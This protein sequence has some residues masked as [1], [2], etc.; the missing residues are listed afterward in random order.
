MNS[1]NV[2]VIKDETMGGVEREYREVKRKAKVGERVKVVKVVI[3]TYKK[4][5][6]GIVRSIADDGS[7]VRAYYLDKGDYMPLFHE[8]YV[9]LEPTDIVRIDGSRFRMVD[10]K[11]AKGDRII[12][13]AD[14]YTAGKKRIT[15][16]KPY[17]IT[18]LDYEGE[19]GFNDDCDALRLQFF[20]DKPKSFVIEAESDCPAASDA[21]LLV[22][23]RQID[24]LSD[25]VTKLET[26]VR[27]NAENIVLIEEGVTADI[28]RLERAVGVGRY[29]SKPAKSE[30]CRIDIRNA[31]VERAKA[32]VTELLSARDGK[33]TYMDGVGFVTVDFVIN[34]E[35]RTVVA[36]VRRA[37]VSPDEVRA[38]GIAKAAPDD[39]FNVHI[40]K[41]IALRRALALPI[42]SEY[43]NAPQP[44][45]PRVGDEIE[46][47][48]GLR[49]RLTKVDGKRYSFYSHATKS[50]CNG[51]YYANRLTEYCHIIDDSRDGAE[52]EVAS[53]KR[54]FSVG[55]RVRIIGNS[56]D[57][58]YHFFNIDDVGK[59]VSGPDKCGDYLVKGIKTLEPRRSMIGYDQFVNVVDLEAA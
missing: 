48:G 25:R 49:Y 47:R 56:S 3:G 29:G 6:V 16:G 10:R 26:A 57:I 45:E 20:G 23:Q 59:I 44:T 30:L 4:G 43:V 36:L 24:K 27:V 11:A 5:T 7:G 31:A 9:V 41:A 28:D 13:V 46:W 15:A 35:K 58:R 1:E 40:G 38:R 42:P 50:F 33:Y 18:Y 52:A 19:P 34:R 37:F 14:W 21:K 54:S 8:E 51:V 55:S 39:C 22:L 2:T 12:F 32:D 53:T 17:I